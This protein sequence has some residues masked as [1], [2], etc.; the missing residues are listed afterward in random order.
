MKH[1]TLEQLHTVAKIQPLSTYPFMTRQ[2]R[3]ERWAL[4]L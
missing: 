1:Q 4:L 3:I 2:Q